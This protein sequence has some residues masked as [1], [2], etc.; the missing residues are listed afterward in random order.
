M[1]ANDDSENCAGSGA[2]LESEE[3]SL[4][5]NGTSWT[6][7]CPVCRQR[8]ELGYAGL[9]PVHPAGSADAAD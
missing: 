1:T 5:L 8:L 9:I 6:G 7:E 2:I 4:A 3:T